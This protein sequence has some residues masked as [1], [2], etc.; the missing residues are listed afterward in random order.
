MLR[1]MN[2]I[3]KDKCSTFSLESKKA[4]RVRAE[5]SGASPRPGPRETGRRAHTPG[6][7][8]DTFGGPGA[9]HGHGGAAS[10]S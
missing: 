2:Q 7:A 6:P 1:E 3:E 10:S 8:R 9:Q 5:R 4:E